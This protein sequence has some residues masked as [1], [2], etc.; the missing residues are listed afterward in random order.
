MWLSDVRRATADDAKAA[1]QNLCDA[2]QSVRFNR[3]KEFLQQCMLQGGQ[4]FEGA[5]AHQS[6]VVQT[7]G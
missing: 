4:L 2:E 1:I 6:I 7:G 5:I 3:E